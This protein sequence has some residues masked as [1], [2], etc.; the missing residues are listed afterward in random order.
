MRKSNAKNILIVIM[1]IVLI[2]GV[3]IF[4]LLNN[5]DKTPIINS[6]NTIID[7]DITKPNIGIESIIPPIPEIDVDIGNTDDNNYGDIHI[8]VGSNHM[9]GRD[10][11]PSVDD[12]IIIG[13][14]KEGAN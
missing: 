5:K 12:F 9:T 14:I 1:A 2:V 13:G 3:G 4:V 7:T 8:G 6:N 10:E 11:S